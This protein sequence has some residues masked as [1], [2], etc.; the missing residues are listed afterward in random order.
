MVYNML[1]LSRAFVTCQRINVILGRDEALLVDF[2]VL[3]ENILAGVL[4]C[5]CVLFNDL[6]LFS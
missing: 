2:V 5:Y 4:S 3:G 6:S 1:H